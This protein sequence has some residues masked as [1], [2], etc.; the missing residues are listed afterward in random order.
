MSATFSTPGKAPTV[1]TASSSTAR[2]PRSSTTSSA[3]N[4]PPTTGK[5][6]VICTCSKRWAT[7]PG[8]TSGTFPRG[9][10][11]PSKD[12]TPPP[13]QEKT[14]VAEKKRRSIICDMSARRTRPGEA[15]KSQNG[16]EA[17][18]LLR[19]QIKKG[20]DERCLYLSCG[21]RTR[22]SDLW[23]MSP[24]SYQLLHPAMF[25]VVQRYGS[26]TKNPNNK[27]LNILTFSVTL[28]RCGAIFLNFC[29]I[30][31]KSSVRPTAKKPFSP[32]EYI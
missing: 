11:F 12:S 30:R 23:V 1:P 18:S 25:F 5:W 10:S 26:C 21:S 4:A 27:L 8:G 16:T 14:K 13:K 29:T 2:G 32:P 3:P 31:N 6:R 15:Q 7:K 9:K 22:T 19:P 20:I 28:S 17:G 24:T